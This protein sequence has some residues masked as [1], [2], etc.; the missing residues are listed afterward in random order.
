MIIMGEVNAIT[1][2]G[3]REFLGHAKDIHEAKHIVEKDKRIR[4]ALGL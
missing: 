3:K 4:K 1:P 2:K